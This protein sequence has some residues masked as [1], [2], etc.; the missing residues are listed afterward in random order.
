MVARNKHLYTMRYIFALILLLICTTGCY[1][2]HADLVYP[3]STTCNVTS[4]TYSST[5][6]GILSP[7]CYSCHGG[8]ASAGAGIKLDTYTSL[9]VYISNGQLMNSISHTGTIPGMPLNASQLS[10]CDITT[11]QTWI[12]N[13]TPNN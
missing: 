7:S 10:S 12:N 11:I 2:D 8:T 6:T 3:Q 9:K 5:V 1:Y 4:V 13:G